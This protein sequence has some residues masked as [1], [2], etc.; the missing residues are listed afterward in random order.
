MP[1]FRARAE[2]IEARKLERLAPSIEAA[3]S[4]RDP[5]RPAPADYAFPAMPQL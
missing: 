4:R 2:E 1:E 3:L 5:P